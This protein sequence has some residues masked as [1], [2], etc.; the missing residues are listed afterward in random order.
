M[1]NIAMRLGLLGVIGVGALVARPFLSGNVGDLNVGDCFDEPTIGQ[2]VEDVQHHPCTD[3][4]TG[5]VVFLHDLPDAK[6]VVYPSDTEFATRI[7]ALCVPAFD[8]YTGL[9]FQSD[10]T[11]TMGYFTPTSEGWAGG[12]RG[13]TCYA[14]RIDSKPTTTSIKAGG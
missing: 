7:D 3:A 4:H 6:D 2:T 14:A 1:R 5:E 9:D 13:V 8:A 10:P 12:D 11:W